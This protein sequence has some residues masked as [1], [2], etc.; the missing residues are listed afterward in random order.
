MLSDFYYRLAIKIVDYC[1]RTGHENID[2]CELLQYLNAK[3]MN[4]KE[5]INEED[6]EKSLKTMNQLNGNYKVEKRNGKLFI[7]MGR[8][9]YNE[10]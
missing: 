10:A 8:Q 5:K 6:V 9:I 1:E 4:T 7:N 3:I 2:M